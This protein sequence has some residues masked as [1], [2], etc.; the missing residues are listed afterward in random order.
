[1]QELAVFVEFA[2]QRPDGD[3][4]QENGDVDPGAEFE[5]VNDAQRW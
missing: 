4:G 3:A 5:Q 1:M 2:G